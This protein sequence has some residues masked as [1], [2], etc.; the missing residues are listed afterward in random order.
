MSERRDAIR[1]VI[2][3]FTAGCRP[4]R[5]TR[6]VALSAAAVAAPP[7]CDVAPAVHRR[8]LRRVD[9]VPLTTSEGALAC[10]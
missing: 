4:D 3:R 2:E 10:H 8:P 5:L 6:A 9:V 7:A 1:P